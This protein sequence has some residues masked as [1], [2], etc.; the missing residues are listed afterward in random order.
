MDSSSA[1][2]GFEGLETV[3]AVL[4][5]L[6]C[7]WVVAGAIA[8]SRYRIAPR[9]TTDLDLLI[10]WNDALVGEFE[11]MGYKV[12]TFADPGEQPHLVTLSK[13]IERIDL[14]VASGEYQNT[15][16]QRGERLR[17][18]APED[19]IIHKLIAW[20]PRD[21]DDV[22]SILAA[23]HELDLD[24]IDRWAKEWEVDDRWAEVRPRS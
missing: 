1:Q 14:L 18:L 6:G 19:V 5:R 16:I 24:Y 22:A 2:K 9:H 11:S 15:A 20:R 21:R 17:V 3:T 23:G 13:G 8:A 7:K 12:K 4:D 10:T